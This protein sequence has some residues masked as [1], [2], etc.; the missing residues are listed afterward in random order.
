VYGA[1]RLSTNGK[2]L[3]VITLSESPDVT[4]SS[5]PMII[6][7]AIGGVAAAVAVVVVAVLVYRR[8]QRFHQG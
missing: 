7:G 2:P 1:E 8:R 4:P 5:M 6:G 3:K